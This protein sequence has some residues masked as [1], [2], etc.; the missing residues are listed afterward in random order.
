M[1]TRDLK[2]INLAPRACD[3]GAIRGGRVWISA[4]NICRN[5]GILCEILILQIP[6]HT[7]VLFIPDSV[8]WLAL[9]LLEAA[10][11]VPMAAHSVA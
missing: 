6:P 11:A 8:P 5:V 2:I 7:Q 1:G 10:L 3:T 4:N 9:P